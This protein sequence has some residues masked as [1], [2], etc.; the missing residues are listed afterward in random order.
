MNAFL[1]HPD[2]PDVQPLNV[3]TLLK[4]FYENLS[5]NIWVPYKPAI[6]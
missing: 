4:K 5:L 3:T 1:G 2:L 6:Y